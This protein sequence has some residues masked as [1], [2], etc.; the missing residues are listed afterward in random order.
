MLQCKEINGSTV[1]WWLL[2]ES[3]V[4]LWLEYAVLDQVKS[5]GSAL[6]A[7]SELW[8]W[9]VDGFVWSR[10]GSSHNDAKVSLQRVAC[11]KEPSSPVD[12]LLTEPR[13]NDTL[14]MQTQ[15]DCQPGSKA[16]EVPCPAQVRGEVSMFSGPRA[17]IV[18]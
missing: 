11:P 6:I 4:D 16:N 10:E 3:G 17:T 12:V 5:H 2:I 13:V 8:Q 9:R 14:I 15:L 18:F 7:F 1:Y